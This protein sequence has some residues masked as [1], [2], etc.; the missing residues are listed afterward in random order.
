MAMPSVQVLRRS[1]AGTLKD[2][3]P[4]FGHEHHG[5]LFLKL[6]IL[7]F[8]PSVDNHRFCK[9]LGVNDSALASSAYNK[10]GY[11]V[12]DADA[13][14]STYHAVQLRAIMDEKYRIVA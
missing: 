3:Q 10:L 9:P 14:S 7:Q 2:I 1:C 6:P 13:V 4:P 8:L 5:L 11:V 12:S